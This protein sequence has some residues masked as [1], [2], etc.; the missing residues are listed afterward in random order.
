MPV[1]S[2]WWFLFIWVRRPGTVVL[3][4][5]IFSYAL[6]WLIY[7]SIQINT[8]ALNLLLCMQTFILTL[9]LSHTFSI[10][11]INLSISMN[12]WYNWPRNFKISVINRLFKGLI[13]IIFFFWLRSY[14]MFICL[15]VFL[16]FL[17]RSL[18]YFLWIYIKQY[19]P[20]LFLLFIAYYEPISCI[21]RFYESHIQIKGAYLFILLDQIFQTYW[22]VHNLSFFRTLEFKFLIPFRILTPKSLCFEMLLLFF[23]WNGNICGHFVKH[24]REITN[25]FAFKN[26]D[27]KFK[28][29]LLVMFCF[30]LLLLV[31][32][33]LLQLGLNSICLMSRSLILDLLLYRLVLACRLLLKHH[34][35]TIMASIDALI[36]GWR[37]GLFLLHRLL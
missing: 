9:S 21:I 1:L 16:S 23:K 17:G 4:H 12:L 11:A 13:Y 28:L 32:D 14:W 35:F 33:F 8:S 22:D 2:I 3:N 29:F 34:I 36:L 5:W 37:L 6:S 10:V 18:L 24:W 26:P 19:W 27:S 31:L 20:Y 7:L 15:Y 25:K 30:F